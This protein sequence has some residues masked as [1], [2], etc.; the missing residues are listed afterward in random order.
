VQAKSKNQTGI[1][2]L[3]HFHDCQKEKEGTNV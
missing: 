2:D 3:P 1:A